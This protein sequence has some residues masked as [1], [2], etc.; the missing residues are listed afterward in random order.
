ML[1]PVPL[2]ARLDHRGAMLFQN[3]R[4]AERGQRLGAALARKD[5]LE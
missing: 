4:V 2:Q 3:L 1:L 5:R